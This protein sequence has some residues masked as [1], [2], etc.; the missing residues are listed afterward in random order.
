MADV[1]LKAIIEAEDRASREFDK[2][3]NSAG[4]LRTHLA[5]VASVAKTVAAGIGIAAGG[6]GF[7]MKTTTDASN[8]L[9]SSLLGLTSVAN[10]LGKN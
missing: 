2:V 10:A 1:K 9:S 4:G 8:E 6:L 7:I 5:S 3:G